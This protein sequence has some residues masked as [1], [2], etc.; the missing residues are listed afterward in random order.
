[1]KVKVLKFLSLYESLLKVYPQGVFGDPISTV[2]V[3]FVKKAQSV[4]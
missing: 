4:C 2:E 1:M 3:D